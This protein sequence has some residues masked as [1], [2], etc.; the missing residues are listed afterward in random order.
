MN[1]FSVLWHKSSQ[2]KE[3]IWIFCKMPA[4]TDS[5]WLLFSFLRKCVSTHVFR[6]LQFCSTFIG[7][8]HVL[9]LKHLLAGSSISEAGVAI[10]TLASICNRELG[11]SVTGIKLAFRG[12][13]KYL[14]IQVMTYTCRRSPHAWV[15]SLFFFK[16]T[17]A[18]SGLSFTETHKNLQ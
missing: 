8:Y 14:S 2:V 16:T 18:L 1:A 7:E 9:N 4:K 5:L 12:L 13:S 15:K 10:C 3:N 17:Q 11:S 6:V